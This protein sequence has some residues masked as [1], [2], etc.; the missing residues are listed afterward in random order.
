MAKPSMPR[1]K[2]CNAHP[3]SSRP[4]PQ[5]PDRRHAL[6]ALGGL[7]L[8]LLT[9]GAARAA[10]PQP[11]LTHILAKI[12]PR[13]PAPDFSLPDMDGKTHKLS[14]Y[15]GKV[16]MLNFW[17][18][19]CPPCRREMPSMEALHQSMKGKPFQ[20]LACNQQESDNTVWA[21]TAQLSP[22]P[23]FPIL[24]DSKSAVSETFNVAGLPTTFI[25]DKAGMIAYRAVGGREFD[26]PD[27]IALLDRL[28]A[29]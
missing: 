14:D 10:L 19:W 29:E 13:R 8:G 3:T 12:D 17:A 28:I 22:E 21:F 23:T 25:V 9:A 4:G 1:S 7:G 20:V 15:R 24:L 16:V 11:P 2:A 18:T 5:N 27:I 6:L 26:H